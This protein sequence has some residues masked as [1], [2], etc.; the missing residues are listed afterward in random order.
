MTPVVDVLVLMQPAFLQSVLVPQVQFL[1]R[2]LDIPAMLQLQVQKLLIFRSCR[3]SGESRNAW[4]D[5]G[6]L[7]CVSSRMAFG[8][9]HVFYVIG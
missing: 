5:S 8:K 2:I 4:F 9:F 3:S 6:Y 1:D 7:F